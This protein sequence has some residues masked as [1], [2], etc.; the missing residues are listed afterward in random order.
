MNQSFPRL[1]REDVIEFEEVIG[2]HFDS[3]KDSTLVDALKRLLRD[4]ELW[5]YDHLKVENA[6]M[7]AKNVRRMFFAACLTQPN[8]TLRIDRRALAAVSNEFLNEFEI[9]SFE[10]HASMETVYRVVRQRPVNSTYYTEY[11]HDRT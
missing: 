5:N 6:R 3:T 7:E 1:T 4:R 10:D 8:R 9:Q 11:D 2:H